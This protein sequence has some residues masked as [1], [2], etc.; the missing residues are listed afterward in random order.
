MRCASMRSAFGSVF[1]GK[2]C[3]V[4]SVWGGALGGIIADEAFADF[5]R[6]GLGACVDTL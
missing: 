5:A 3:V 1:K 6:K 4:M 2:P